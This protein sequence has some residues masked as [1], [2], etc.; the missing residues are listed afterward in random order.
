ME[1]RGWCIGSAFGTQ[2]GRGVFLQTAEIAAE[3]G[4]VLAFKVRLRFIQI[5]IHYTG[6]SYD[7]NFW[8][9][10]PSNADQSGATAAHF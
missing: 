9:N 3:V 10:K 5:E 8:Q 7:F 6:A 4:T 1:A 2:Y